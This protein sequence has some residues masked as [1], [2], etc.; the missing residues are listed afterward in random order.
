MFARKTQIVPFFQIKRPPENSF[1][2][3]AAFMRSSSFLCL[4]NR[5]LLSWFCFEIIISGTPNLMRSMASRVRP[6][7]PPMLSWG[8]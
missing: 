1:E 2:Y 5:V 3:P 7:I 8:A 4:F 6:S